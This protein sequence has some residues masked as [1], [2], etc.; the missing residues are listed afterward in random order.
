MIGIKLPIEK[1]NLM[2]NYLILEKR[3]WKN[4]KNKNLLKKIQRKKELRKKIKNN[5]KKMQVRKILRKKM[6]S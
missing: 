1:P 3:L 2:L 5:Q 4:L 6:L